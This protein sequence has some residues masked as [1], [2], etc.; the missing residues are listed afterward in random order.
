LAIVS[1]PYGDAAVCVSEKIIQYAIYVVVILFQD[2]FHQVIAVRVTQVYIGRTIPV[3][4]RRLGKGGKTVN[5]KCDD[6]QVYFHCTADGS[7]TMLT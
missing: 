1:A 4:R 5:I 7:K 2:Q 3:S 6:K